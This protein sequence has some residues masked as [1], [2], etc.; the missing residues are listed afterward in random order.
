MYAILRKANYDTARLAGAAKELEEFQE[1]HASQPGFR[2][3]MEIDAG[4][5]ERFIL[6]LWESEEYAAA[7]LPRMIPVAQRLLEP[8]MTGRSQLLAEGPVHSSSLGRP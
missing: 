1:I 7:A 5:G 6:N 8:L 3:T 2:G 4:A